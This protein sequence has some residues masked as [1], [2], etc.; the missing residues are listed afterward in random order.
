MSDLS[1]AQ[2]A[3]LKRM[4]GSTR[5]YRQI[6]DPDQREVQWYTSDGDGDGK[7]DKKVREDT[8]QALIDTGMV[9][10]SQHDVPKMRHVYSRTDAG[11]EAVES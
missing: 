11:R 10:L 8:A 9:E 7:G 1:D 5:L 6:E 4:D 2:K 3:V